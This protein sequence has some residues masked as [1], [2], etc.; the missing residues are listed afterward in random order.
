MG[1]IQ[2]VL[3]WFY[4][5]PYPNEH[6]DFTLNRARTVALIDNAIELSYGLWEPRREEAIAA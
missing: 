3:T 1:F 4:Y 5:A 2:V 6:P